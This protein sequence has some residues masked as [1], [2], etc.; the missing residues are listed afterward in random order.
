MHSTAE[1]Y[2]NSR[3]GESKQIQKFLRKLDLVRQSRK[4]KFVRE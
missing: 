1:H 2:Q 4:D 3:A